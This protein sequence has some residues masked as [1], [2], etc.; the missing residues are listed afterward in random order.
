MLALSAL[1]ILAC[2][3]DNDTGAAADD[4]A[5]SGT[6]SG[7]G[8]T[9]GGLG[10]PGGS[11]GDADLPDPAPLAELSAG[12]CPAFQHNVVETFQSGSDSR[13]VITLL[14]DEPGEDMPVVFVWH[15]LGGDA[16]YMVRAFDLEQWA[17]IY[18]AVI[19]VPESRSGN[20]LEWDFWNEEEDDLTLYDDL[21]TCAA[22]N[23]SV[24][25]SRVSSFG[26]SAGALWASRLSIERGDTF[27]TVAIASGGCELDLPTGISYVA[28]EPPAFPFPALAIWGGESDTYGISGLSV[29]FEDS[30]EN[31]RE[32]LVDNEHYVVSCNHE[33][34][35][36]IPNELANPVADW[37]LS[38][39]YG[40]ASPYAS[41]GI[42]DFPDYCW[43]E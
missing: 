4:T 34:G 25:L 35:H 11:G 15:P 13:Q 31:Y 21:R 5:L 17:D 40:A 39:T 26:F 19:I 1:L 20:L 42:G 41:A 8:G 32:L 7:S 30:M 27:S 23:L 24:D 18:G 43:E 29:Y 12:D 38:H 36:T 33:R 9:D 16:S 22:N 10:G 3:P 28:C 6:G 14:P 2:Q 37:L